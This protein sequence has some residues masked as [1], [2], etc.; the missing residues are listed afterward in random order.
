MQCNSAYPT[1]LKDL[2]LN[3]LENFKK[4]YKVEVGFSDQSEGIIAPIIAGS[5]IK[6]YRKTFYNFKKTSR[7]R[8][9]LQF[10]S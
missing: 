1:P 2:N 10:I 6:I 3:V 5:W 9:Y 7:S 4:K 8:S